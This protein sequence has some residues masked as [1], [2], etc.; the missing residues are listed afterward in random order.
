MRKFRFFYSAVYRRVREREE[1]AVVF[2]KS[3]FTRSY[4]HTKTS[5]IILALT[6]ENENAGGVI[7]RRLLF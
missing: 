2:P 7:K 1:V 4:T 3:N 5:I 6:W